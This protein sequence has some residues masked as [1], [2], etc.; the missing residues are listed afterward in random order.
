MVFGNKNINLRLLEAE[1]KKHNPIDEVWI[2]KQNGTVRLGYARK[3]AKPRING[4]A[5]V[6][7]TFQLNPH[8]KIQHLM[9][10]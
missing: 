6:E 7:V 10:N 4:A 8:T 5:I 9:N 2:P 1:K 3:K